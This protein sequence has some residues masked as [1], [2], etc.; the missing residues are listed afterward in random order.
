[1]YICKLINDDGIVDE[2]FY[3]TGNSAQEVKEGLEMFQW[4]DG[5]WVINR[6]EG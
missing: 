4:P 1:M 6:I 3:R 2:L 5:E